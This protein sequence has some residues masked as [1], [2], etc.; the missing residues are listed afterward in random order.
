MGG[1]LFHPG[2]QDNTALGINSLLRE[3]NEGL[4]MGHAVEKFS[5][6]VG[7]LLAQTTLQLIGCSAIGLRCRGA[8]QIHDRLGL[9]QIQ[10]S[11]EKGP[12]REFPRTG[13]P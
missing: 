1:D 4:Q 13:H 9:G 12:L 2:T 3:V 6:Q 10:L 5:T 7:D 11:V 8:D